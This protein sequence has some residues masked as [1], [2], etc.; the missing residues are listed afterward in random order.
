M[1]IIEKE[2]E[3]VSKMDPP[4]PTKKSNAL[5]TKVMTIFTP[6]YFCYT[7]TSFIYLF[8]NLGGAIQN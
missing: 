7:L 4:E 5:K 3:N 8:F 2:F 6:T 1:T